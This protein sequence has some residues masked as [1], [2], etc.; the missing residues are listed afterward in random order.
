MFGKGKNTK[1]EPAI[2]NNDPI[3]SFLGK[4]MQIK[5]DLQ[6]SGKARIDGCVEGDVR[7]GSLVLSESSRIK[8]NVEVEALICQ[9]KIDG[10][11]KVQN[12]LVKAGGIVNGSITAADLLVESGGIINGEV[13]VPSKEL[14]VVEKKQPVK[15][16]PPV[17]LEQKA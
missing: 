5:G 11:L 13:S 9:G 10:D 6:F 3:S 4:D 17:M 15:S 12:L 14:H 8:G 1:S 16:R 7:G 2:S